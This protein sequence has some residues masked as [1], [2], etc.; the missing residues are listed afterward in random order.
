MKCPS[1]GAAT[2]GPICAS[3]GEALEG[4]FPPGSIPAVAPKFSGMAIAGFVLAFVCGLL[5]II[6]SALGY[7]ECKKS[8]GAV[9]GRGLAIAGMVISIVTLLV[10][11]LSVIAVPAFLDYM[12]KTPRL[13][14]EIELRK[15]ERAVREHHIETDALPTGSATLTP[16]QSCCDGGCM[17]SEAEFAASGWRTLDFEVSG[18]HRFRYSFESDGKHF[19]AKAVGDLDCDGTEIVYELA[20][21][22]YGGDLRSTITRPPPNSD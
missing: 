20:I 22:V 18:R 19:V 3:C 16:A 5:G 4:R 15:I 1:C 7:S 12:K 11:L 17:S 13:E 14:A 9:R 10:A 21:E 8:G 2:T 6:F